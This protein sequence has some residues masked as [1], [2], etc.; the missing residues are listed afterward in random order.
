MLERG[1]ERDRQAGPDGCSWHPAEETF[2]YICCS[3]LYNH[4]QGRK[5]SRPGGE[6]E[7]LGDVERQKKPGNTELAFS[8][9]GK[10]L[11]CRIYVSDGLVH[12]LPPSAKE[13]RPSTAL[14]CRAAESLRVLSSSLPAFMLTIL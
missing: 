11:S 5:L 9:E 7:S 12:E 1:C 8:A 6:Q 4:L 14:L 13:V 3:G 2:A 10:L